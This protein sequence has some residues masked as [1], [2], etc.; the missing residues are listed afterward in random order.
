MID[1]Y[2]LRS[3][4]LT[5]YF[6]FR[7][8][9]HSRRKSIFLFV[10]RGTGRATALPHFCRHPRAFPNFLQ[11]VQAARLCWTNYRPKLS[12]MSR[13]ECAAAAERLCGRAQVVV[14]AFDPVGCRSV[15]QMWRCSPDLPPSP[16]PCVLCLRHNKSK[17]SEAEMM[18]ASLS[19]WFSCRFPDKHAW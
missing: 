1:Y 3:Y 5:L 17:E 15:V 7:R 2:Y 4:G 10:F 16:S 9:K 12:L 8:F 13:R 18:M 11:K 14:P 19:G 6:F